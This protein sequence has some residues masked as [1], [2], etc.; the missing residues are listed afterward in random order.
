MRK[1]REARTGKEHL[2]DNLTAKRRMREFHQ[3][4]GSKR[5]DERSFREIDEEAIWFNFWK[6]GKEYKDILKAKMPELAQNLEEKEE[7]ERKE[8]ER[9][10]EEI[11][12]RSNAKL[13]AGMWMMNPHTEEYYWTGEGPPPEGEYEMYNGLD[14]VEK[15]T[16]EWG[17]P[18]DEERN[19]QEDK[20]WEELQSKWFQEEMEARR[21]ERRDEKNRIQRE[22]YHQTKEL[23]KEKIEIPDLEK[24]EYE[25]L[26]E[27]NIKEREEAMRASGWFSD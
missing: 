9:K 24:S 27:R 22:K 20:E 7:N 6:S 18:L 26:R 2:L 16:D 14:E 3:F 11:E 17:R 5:F 4:G 12:K 23:L 21:K 19:R 8:R 10:R 25:L 13:K 1:L 15:S